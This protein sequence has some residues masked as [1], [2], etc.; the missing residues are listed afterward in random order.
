MGGYVF[1]NKKKDY[2]KAK[3]FYEKVLAIAKDNHDKIAVEERLADLEYE[4]RAD[5]INEL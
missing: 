1:F 4:M 5:K 3:E 2:A